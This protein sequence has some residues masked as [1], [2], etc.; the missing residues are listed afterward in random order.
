MDI[1][2]IGKL[3]GNLINGWFQRKHE[4][5]QKELQGIQNTDA[6]EFV[7]EYQKQKNLAT[8]WK[9]EYIT[10]LVTLPL[11]LIFIPGVEPHVLGGFATLA[12]TPEWYQWVM[13]GVITTG[14]GI[15]MY[16]KLRKFNKSSE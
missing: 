5:Q 3:V 11:W 10:V 12:Q 2:G 7:I 4:I 9:D 15:P 8:S 14:A 16:G 13:M 6:N 1:M